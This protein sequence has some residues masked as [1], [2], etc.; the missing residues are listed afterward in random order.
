MYLYWPLLWLC[1]VI[2]IK[3]FIYIG[4]YCGYGW[5][6]IKIFILAFISMGNWPQTGRR[7]TIQKY[8]LYSRVGQ[9]FRI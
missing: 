6:G 3:I 9:F 4:L 5:L 8:R 2:G 1:L 7:S